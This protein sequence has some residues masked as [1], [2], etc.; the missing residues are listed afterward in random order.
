ML[1]L[2]NIIQRPSFNTTPKITISSQNRR[3]EYRGFTIEGIKS[4]IPVNHLNKLKNIIQSKR[5]SA[6]LPKYS[7]IIY[8][9][10]KYLK[11][12]AISN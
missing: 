10:L 7:E 4:R 1:I 3:I 11:R 12:I 5:I 8:L 6:S 9:N 2:Q